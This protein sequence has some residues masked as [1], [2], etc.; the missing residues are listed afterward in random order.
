MK[1]RFLSVLAS[2]AFML[3]GDGALPAIAGQEQS[4]TRSLTV[5]QKAIHD[6]GPGSDTVQ[7]DDALKVVAWVD[8]ADYAYAVGEPVRIYVETNKD[9][10]VTVLNTD[11]A[12]QTTQIFP[13]QY[14]QDNFIRANR[15]IELPD[16]E[17]QSRIV[18]TGDVGDELL[19]VM[20]STSPVSLFE[21]GQLSSSGPFRVVRTSVQGTVRS[22]TVVMDGQP[23]PGAGAAAPSATTGGL[24]PV[25]TGSTGGGDTEWAVCHQKIRTFAAST[26]ALRT[27]SLVVRRND[28]GDS[29]RCEE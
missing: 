29:V 14:Q 15:T 10:Y 7:D 22:L 5:E 21:D 4:F 25:S 28:S 19:K 3:V 18:V 20:A 26:L 23:A 11:P 9:A 13:N 8:R 27:R 6:V 1:C 16:P 2:A 17:S 24:I 12:G